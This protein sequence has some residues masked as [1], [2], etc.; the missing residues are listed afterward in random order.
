ML[1]LFCKKNFLRENYF[2]EEKYNSKNFFKKIKNFEHGIF[3]I[4]QLF[5]KHVLNLPLNFRICQFHVVPHS[6]S[7]GKRNFI[8]PIR[9][10]AVIEYCICKSKTADPT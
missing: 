4:N 5:D 7:I 10:L 1:K 3:K 9:D 6:S 2:C 8:S